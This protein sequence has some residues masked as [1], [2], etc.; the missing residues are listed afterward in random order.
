MEVR[1]VGLPSIMQPIYEPLLPPLKTIPSNIYCAQDYERAAR[2][3][4]AS[5]VFD[6]I[7]GGSGQDKTLHA[8]INAFDLWAITP[9]LLEDVRGA[10]TELSLL[11]QTF[12]H[13]VFLAP[14]A[15]QTLVHSNGEID[16]ARAAAATDSGFIASCLSSCSL[17][18]ISRLI[19]EKKWFQLYFQP[20]QAATADLVRRAEDAGYK[21]IIVTLDTAIRQPSFNAQRSG[22]IMPDSI[23]A[24]NLTD[25]PLANT[26]Q[27]STKQSRIF[28]SMMAY[29]P[30]WDSLEWLIANTRL[31]V[32]VKGVLH[33]DDAI[34]LKSM[35]VAAIVVSNHGGR[36]LDGAP[37]ALNCLAHIR[38][39]V[40][41]DYPLLFDSGIRSGSDVFKA[42]ALG[43]NAVLIGRLQIYAL[44][45]AGALGVAHML[46]LL[47]E[48]FEV[49]MAMTGCKSIA[50]VRSF[51]LDKC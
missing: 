37:A 34:R 14:V 48:E 46:K 5:P 30:R 32:I 50:E 18:D 36:T 25:Y 2:Q 29:A 31:P 3:F 45:V 51:K 24:A 49:V 42:I 6:Y 26:A 8:N 28:D 43:A 35:G 17:E 15:F 13:P 20:I 23:V 47:R 4:I 44:G 7:A 41:V 33:A 39:A 12:E 21:A 1:A 11:N 27:I 40:G 22:F 9:R 38:A 16:V 19:P 10:N